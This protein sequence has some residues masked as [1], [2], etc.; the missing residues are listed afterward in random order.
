[1]VQKQ[2]ERHDPNYLNERENFFHK[3]LVNLNHFLTIN[4]KMRLSSIAYWSGGSGGGTGTYGSIVTRDAAGKSDTYG[5]A[6]KSGKHKFYYGPSPWTRD[7]NEQI[8]INSSTGTSYWWQGKSKSKKA[9]ESIGILRNSI[10]RQGTLGL[11]SKLNYD[12]NDALRL[13]FGIDWRTAGIEHARE[14]RDLLGGNF[15]YQLC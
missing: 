9:G 5:A 6:A 15:L 7:W 4:D 14:V 10:N 11:I 1:M 12:M 2:V 8:A 13:Q 3:P